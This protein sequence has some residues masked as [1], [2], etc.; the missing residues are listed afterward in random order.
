[1]EELE[2][3]K[4]SYARSRAL[5]LDRLPKMGLTRFAPPDGA[6]YVYADV[7]SFTRDSAQFCARLLDEAGVATTPGLDFDRERGAEAVRFSYA[8]DEGEVALGMDRLAAWLGR[9]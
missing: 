4:A 7:S 1:V 2:A 8:G 9:L 5:L 3:Y 6:F